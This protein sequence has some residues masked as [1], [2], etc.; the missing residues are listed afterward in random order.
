MFNKPT[1]GQTVEPS[2]DD[3]MC[4]GSNLAVTGIVKKMWND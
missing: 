2:I 3:L 4:E 1:S